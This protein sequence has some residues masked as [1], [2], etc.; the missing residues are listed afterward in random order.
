MIRGQSGGKDRNWSFDPLSAEN[1]P[2]IMQKLVT[3]DEY[4]AEENPL[5]VLASIVDQ[6]LAELPEHL[7]EPV[8]LVCLNGMSY[9]SAGELIGIDHKTVKRRVEIGL[10]LLRTRLLDTAWIASMLTGMLPEDT[11]APR[12]ETSSKVVDILTALKDTED[13][14]DE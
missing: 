5:T 4:F 9:R 14:S 10:E 1:I 12:L 3:E 13:K 2:E 6:I 8:N 7:A 11:V